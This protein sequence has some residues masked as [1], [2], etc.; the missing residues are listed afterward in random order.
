MGK[1][2]Y[3]VTLSERAGVIAGLEAP[4]QP[5]GTRGFPWKSKEYFF[6]FFSIMV[7]SRDLKWLYCKDIFD[8]SCCLIVAPDL[9]KNL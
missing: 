9:L 3:S 4:S 8:F 7:H 2:V 1:R 5:S 6:L